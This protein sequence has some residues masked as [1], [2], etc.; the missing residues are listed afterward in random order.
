VIGM[1]VGIYGIGGG[2]LAPILLVTG[3]SAYEGA[4]ATITATLL[5][6]IVGVLTY[7]VS[8]LVHGGSIAPD[9]ILG[10]WIGPRRICRQLPRR[11]PPMT[12][13]HPAPKC[14]MG[15]V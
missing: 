1:I 13:S 11:P 15:E 10:A 8:E 3:Y 2:L 5:T 6:S 14:G 4:P 7:Q 12:G 9:W